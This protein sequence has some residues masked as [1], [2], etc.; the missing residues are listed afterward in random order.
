VSVLD[1]VQSLGGPPAREASATE[2]W[3]IVD[4]GQDAGRVSAYRR[5]R[6][7]E[8]VQRQGLFAFDDGDDF[9]MHPTTRVLVALSADGDVVGGVRIHAAAPGGETIGWWQGSRLVVD[10]A[11]RRL[12][13]QIGAALVRAACVRALDVGAL[14]FDAHVQ[15]SQVAFFERLGWDPVR[16][17]EVAGRPHRLMRWSVERIRELVSATKEPLGMLLAPLLPRDR[18]RGDDGVPVPGSD[19]VACVDAITPSMVQR[20]PEW[21]G[22]CGMLVTAHDLAAMGA[23]PV[24]ALDALG[25]ADRNHAERVLA[26]I[27]RG[28]EALGLPVLGG[29]TQLGVPAA[30]SVTGVGRA[31]TPVPA[32]G[33]RV[34]DALTLT[35][36]VA[37]GW[38]PGYAGRQWDSTSWRSREELAP[39]LSAVGRAAPHAA[40]DVSMAGLVGTVAMLAEASGTGAEL[41]V[42]AVPRPAAATMSDWLTCFPGM[43]FVTADAPDAPLP[44]AGECVSAR[45]GR[46]QSTAGVRLRWPDGDVTGAV[47]AGTASGL[48]AARV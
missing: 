9:D 1:I 35:A 19:V 44:E 16:E 11:A 30:L 21:A 18:W 34:G 10:A 3:L 33:G 32:G 45:C 7:R 40:K 48:G 22:W 42:D 38:R 36:D 31:C 6:R 23:D 47:P 25:A 24:G 46:L 27:R 5:L 43:A 8:F 15:E 12:R 4:A 13:G 17:I 29:H 28:A 41:D 26:G 2:P 39:M 14:R 37:G 20:D